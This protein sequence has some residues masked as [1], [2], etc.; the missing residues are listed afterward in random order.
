VRHARL[1]AFC[2][3]LISCGSAE[4][5]TGTGGT[6]GAAGGTS[7]ASGASGNSGATA[8]SSGG[9][10]AGISGSAGTSGGAGIGGNTG[11]GGS[12]AG[13]AGG[14]GGDAGA[15]G[16]AG[17]AGAAGRGGSGG[18]AGANGGAGGR[19]G[20]GTGGAAG[21]GGGAGSNGGRG[22]ATAG[23]GGATA[24]SGGRGGGAGA[25]G[26]AGGRG[27][28]GGSPDAGTDGGG[29]FNP[30]PA[31]GNCIIMPLG[32]SITDGV[33]SSGSGGG[34]RVPL[35]QTAV[36]NMDLITFVGRNVNGPT[37]PV[38]GKT[39]PR[40][41]EGY[42][43][44]TIDPGGGRS[45]ISPLV[46]AAISMF[47][48]HIVTLMIGTN[49]VNISLDLTNAPTRLGNLL[50]RITTDAPNALVVIAQLT[51]TTNDTTNGR[52]RTYNNAIPGLVA[53]RVAAGKHIVVVDM[54]GAFTANSSY[55]TALMNDELHPNDAGYVVMANTWYAAIRS[56]LPSN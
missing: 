27:G 47:H 15:G 45:G 1:I 4:I 25:G 26:S 7:G 32:D 5:R 31:S 34:Y 50:D 3:V 41:H 37:T 42:S 21:A 20:A 17:A 51:P 36:T 38:A 28:S 8:G 44:Y 23:S 52:V 56:Y 10:T 30:C 6:S 18:A 53:T 43:G 29:A 11:T 48:P 12:S 40:N 2:F 24:G 55:K 46:D 49:D 19:G 16:N 9:A 54:Y 14:R 22:G 35:F 39:F 13:A 33:G